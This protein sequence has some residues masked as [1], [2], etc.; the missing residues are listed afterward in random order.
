MSW[1][2]NIS[3]IDKWWFEQI[4]S[5]YTSTYIDSI[6]PWWRTQQSWY[7]LYA[8]IVVF[9]ILKY[10]TKAISW[11]VSLGLALAV[12]D[13][14]SSHIV[15]NVVAR[16]RPCRD[17]AIIPNLK[18]LLAQCP[19]SYSFTSSHAANHFCMAI[20]FVFTLEP[21]MD[22]WVYLFILWA[23]SIGYAQIYVGVHYPLDVVGGAIIGTTT[24]Y[25]FSKLLALYHKKTA[26]V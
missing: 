13:V 24:G 7:F 21:F 9:V 15:K 20:F 2:H 11:I 8:I 14:I 18:L 6:A 23:A 5:K 17:A 16:L 1:L 4:N 26:A 25:S 19:S 22:K 10:K 3:K 12:T